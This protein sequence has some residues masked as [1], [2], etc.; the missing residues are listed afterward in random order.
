MSQ[1]KINSI[2]DKTGTSGPVIAG[3]STNNSTGCMI[4]PA[5][6][7]GRRVE[8]NTVNDNDIVRDGLILHLDFANPDCLINGTTVRDLSGAGHHSSGTI[9]GAT[10]S[11]DGGGSLLFAGNSG[12]DFG[13]VDPEGPFVLS[14]SGIGITNTDVSSGGDK[15]T[16]CAWVGNVDTSE[17]ANV[18]VAC[19]DSTSSSGWLAAAN[20]T[21][22]SG[23]RPMPAMITS[24]GGDSTG[25]WVRPGWNGPNIPQ[26]DPRTLGYHQTVRS[27]PSNSGIGNTTITVGRNKFNHLTQ[28]LVRDQ[29]NGIWGAF[30]HINGLVNGMETPLFPSSGMGYGV[31]TESGEWGVGRNLR[32]G[33]TDSD[34]STSYMRG[35]IAIVMVYNKSLSDAEIT[36]NFN[37]QRYRFGR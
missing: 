17:A 6:N 26:Y 29:V 18:T 8:Y 35:N 31:A 24:D 22:D 11:S 7:T 14:S 36:Q 13:T 9:S 2:T 12:V 15:L 25:N 20:E 4:I 23:N 10:Y 30:T 34:S 3:V 21:N 33:R 27:L 37:A 32:I 28:R 1:F 16:V 19:W 5:G